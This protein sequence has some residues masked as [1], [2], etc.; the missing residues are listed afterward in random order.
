VLILGAGATVGASFAADATVQP[1]LNADF[2]TQLQ[3]VGPKHQATA[4][5]VIKDVVGLFGPNFTLTLEDYFTQLESMI[6]ATRFTPKK[7]APITASELRGCRERLMKGLSAVLEA[8]TDDAVRVGDGCDHHR[9]LVK[10]LQPRDTIISFNYDCVMDHALRTFGGE[11]WSARY[12][13]AFPQPSRVGS[14]G[15]RHW[16]ASPPAS[17]ANSSIYLLKLHGSLNWQLPPADDGEITLKRR[18]HVQRG[19]PRFTIIAPGWSKHDRDQPIFEDL[20]KKAERALRAAQ[21][22]AVVGFSF[23]PTDLHVEAVVR[24]ALARSRS[25]RLLVIVNPSQ[26]HRERIRAVFSKQLGRDVLVRQ[27]ADFKQFTAS[28]PDC[29]TP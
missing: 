29:L 5:T 22:I 14:E 15:D 21:T 19:T 12:G 17:D 24:L 1:P 25:L 23:T 28:L 16:S 18:L 10:H 11:K 3:R 6:D 8:S 7:L 4:R 26:E 9:D 2:F 13:Y 27:Y 20:W